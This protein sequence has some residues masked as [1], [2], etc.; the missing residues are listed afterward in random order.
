MPD[1]YTK[2]VK[3]KKG[4]TYA[5]R[6]GDP[7]YTTDWFPDGASALDAFNAFMI[8]DSGFDT[9]LNAQTVNLVF[10][11]S[12]TGIT[13]S[14]YHGQIYPFRLRVLG[15]PATNSDIIGLA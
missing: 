5:V 1:F 7:G 4:L 10:A 3:L 6:G 11:G 8:A 14:M 13:F 12:N 15:I 2:G 9:V